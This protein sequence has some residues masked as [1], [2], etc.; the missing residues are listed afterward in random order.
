M[1]NGMNKFGGGDKIL[2]SMGLTQRGAA[3]GAGRIVASRTNT[4]GQKDNK[5]GPSI[6]SNRFST[7]PGFSDA[8]RLPSGKQ[9]GMSGMIGQAKSKN[10]FNSPGPVAG[11]FK[12]SGINRPM[13]SSERP[14]EIKKTVLGK[15]GII[16]K[17]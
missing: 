7:R 14:K 1:T 17:K 5:L 12:G 13:V 15:M 2:K 6:E 10:Q 3:S 16:G 9:K 4:V 11:R 8:G